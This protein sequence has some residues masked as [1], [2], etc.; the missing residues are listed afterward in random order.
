MLYCHSTRQDFGI[1][2]KLEG[3]IDVAIISKSEN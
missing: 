2:G 3:K 1:A